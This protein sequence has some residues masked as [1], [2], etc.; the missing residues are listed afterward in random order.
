MKA[1]VAVI[2]SGIMGNGIAH[3]FAAAGFQVV[4]VDVNEKILDKALLSIFDNMK[5]QA[6]KGLMTAQEA[7]ESF[8]RIHKGIQIEDAGKAGLVVEAVPERLDL[9]RSIFSRLDKA[10][11]PGAILATN[12]SSIS[13]AGL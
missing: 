12:T 1:D 13:I 9:K 3:V 10:C 2:G 11:L 4:L 8:K 6:A 7:E 5:R